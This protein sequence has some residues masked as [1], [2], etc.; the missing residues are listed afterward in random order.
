M[1]GGRNLHHLQVQQLADANCVPGEVCGKPVL[2]VTNTG[3]L[4]QLAQGVLLGH[5]FREL[6]EITSQKELSV[7]FVLESVT[8]VMGN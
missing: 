1:G 3:E 2:C 4:L 7:C 6:G 8:L 5:G